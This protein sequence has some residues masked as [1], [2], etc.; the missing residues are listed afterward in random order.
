LIIASVIPAKV[1]MTEAVTKCTDTAPGEA[2]IVKKLFYV[3]LY[4][5]QFGAILIE[6]R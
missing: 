3:G 4:W 5:F 6:N 2:A 1:G